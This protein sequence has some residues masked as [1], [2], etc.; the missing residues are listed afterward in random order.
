MAAVIALYI[1]GGLLLFL[2]VLTLLPVRATVEF[3]EEFSL[4]VRYLFLRFPILP[5]KE[6]PEEES[7]PEPGP[8]ET[9]P[10]KDKPGLLDRVKA[11][12]KREGLAGFLQGLGELIRL[13]LEAVGGLLKGLR[14]KRF[15]LYLCLAGGQDA[16]AAAVRYGQVAAGVYGACGGLFAL[17]PCKRKGVT[18][19]LDYAAADNTVS[20]SAVLSIRPASVLKQAL[21]LFFRGLKPLRKVL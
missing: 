18:V 15:D 21:I 7:P 13:L 4:E 9:S 8:E 2:F 3:R 14:L 10:K 19:D 5:A 1:V 17:M 12:L 20:F 6:G 11:A 16:A